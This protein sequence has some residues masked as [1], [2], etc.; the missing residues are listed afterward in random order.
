[1]VSVLLFISY[2]ELCDSLSHHPHMHSADNVSLSNSVLTVQTKV[3]I[4]NLDTGRQNIILSD[5]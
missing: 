4:V 2:T 3:Y 5:N 1:M